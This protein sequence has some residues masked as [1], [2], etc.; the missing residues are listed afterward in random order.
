MKVAY[1]AV[2]GFAFSVLLWRV[3]YDAGLNDAIQNCPSVQ[4][5]KLAY[6]TQTVHGTY[7]TYITHTNGKA[8][9]T[10]KL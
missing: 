10:R 9:R 5:E 6:S 2:C 3:G 8:K 7:C 1:W 4:G